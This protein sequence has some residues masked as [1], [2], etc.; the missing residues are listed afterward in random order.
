MSDIVLVLL[1]EFVVCHLAEGLAP[2]EEG[3]FDRQA[4]DL[5][6]LPRQPRLSL[7]DQPLTLRKRPY[8]NRLKCGRC[9]RFRNSSCWYRIHRGKCLR[10]ISSIMSAVSSPVLVVVEEPQSKFAPD[11]K[12]W[13]KLFSNGTILVSSSNRGKALAVA[14]E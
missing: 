4:E 8:S 13:D 12:P 2:K 11:K 6:S 14:C 7:V 9:L 5:G 3:L 1:I 10:A